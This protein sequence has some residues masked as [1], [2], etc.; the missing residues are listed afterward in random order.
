MKLIQNLGYAVIER[1]NTVYLWPL[2]KQ[3]RDRRG[4]MPRSLM[5][6]CPPLVLRLIRLKDAKGRP[7]FLLTNVLDKRKL[8]DHCAERIYRLRWGV[9]LMW[10][11]LKQTL[12]HHKLLCKTPQRAEAELDWA[13]AGLWMIQLLGG[14][15][16]AESKRSPQCHST[17]KTLRVLR[18]AISGRRRR[19][20][21]LH[22]ELGLAVKDTYQR[23]G[24]KTARHRPRKRPQRP[25]GSPEARMA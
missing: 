2:E 6:V 11:G 5:N 14:A 7:V 10:R 17:A 19:R 9:E 8:S 1:K 22:A 13:M 3:G 12:G 20:K 25:P 24:S 15:R 21:S 23:T 18:G 16:M 4:R